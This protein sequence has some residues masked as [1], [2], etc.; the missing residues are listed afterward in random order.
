MRVSWVSENITGAGTQFQNPPPSAFDS[1]ASDPPTFSVMAILGGRGAE[2]QRSAVFMYGWDR[3]DHR[4]IVLTVGK[5]LGAFGV[6]ANM[7]MRRFV[8]ALRMTDPSATCEG[9]SN[10][11][12]SPGA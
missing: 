10:V 4:E 1:V 6:K 2:I 3:R 12:V 8:G 11:V 7:K 5:S 9:L